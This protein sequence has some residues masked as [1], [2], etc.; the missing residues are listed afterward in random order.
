MVKAMQI[1][2]K[3]FG[4]REAQTTCDE[5]DETFHDPVWIQEGSCEISKH[6]VLPVQIHVDAA[7]DNIRSRCACTDASR[8]RLSLIDR[9]D[10]LGVLYLFLMMLCVAWENEMIS[11][12]EVSVLRSAFRGLEKGERFSFSL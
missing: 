4:H 1:L 9:M 11:V 3:G 12:L 5:K 10:Q 7:S 2:R 6:R 8:L